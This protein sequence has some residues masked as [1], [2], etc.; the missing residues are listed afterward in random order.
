M[1]DQQTSKR[2]IPTGSRPS[3]I[4]GPFGPNTFPDSHGSPVPPSPYGYNVPKFSHGNIGIYP[5]DVN[6]E[7]PSTPKSSGLHTPSGNNIISERDIHS[8]VIDSPENRIAGGPEFETPPSSSRKSSCDTNVTTPLSNQ[9]CQ[10]QSDSILV[11]FIIS[12]TFAVYY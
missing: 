6:T 8:K 1:N 2:E 5:I 10:Q 9:Q 11:W 3:Q 7:S 12:D 4:H